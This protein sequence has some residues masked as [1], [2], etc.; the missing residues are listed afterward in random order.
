MT[1]PKHLH[2]VGIKGVGMTPLAVIAKQAGIIVTGSDVADTFITDETLARAGITPFIGFSQSHVGRDVDLV[3]ATGAHGGQENVEVQ[4]AKSR[5]IPV[6]MKGE[7]VGEYMQGGILGRSFSGISVAG[8]H[9]KTTTTAMIA[10]IFATAGM[11]PS[12]LTGTSSI[13][14]LGASGALGDGNYFI[15]EA[16]EYATDPKHDRTPQFLWQH[17]EIAVFT[18]IELDH[19][20]IYA[21]VAAV[22]EAFREFADNLPSTGLL[23]GCGDDAHVSEIMARR[24]G[25]SITYG[26]GTGNDYT[27]SAVTQTADGVSF[28]LGSK[29]EG[30]KQFCL[31]VFGEHNC[32]NATAA[33]IVAREAGLETEQ[34]ARGLKLFKGAKRRMERVG[35]LPSGALLYDDYAHH[36]TEIE[37]TLSALRTHF[38]DK[39]I[40]CIFQPHTASRT[41]KLFNE[42]CEALSGAD[43]IILAPIYASKRE[44][45]DTSISSNMLADCLTARGNKAQALPAFEAIREHLA[46]ESY[47]LDTIIITVGAGDIYK[48]QDK[49]CYAQHHAK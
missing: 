41:K 21:D 11:S 4:E 33:I 19:P 7:A 6:L 43:E 2:F 15:A 47:G 34:I 38:P 31:S 32:F 16:D 23:V 14:P 44:E 18:N 24:K 36:P 9:G 10:T 35:T 5:G 28:R 29:P 20:D 46:Q 40:V 49:L 13:T 45:E 12:F 30:H 1:K 3:I 42:F 37:K 27:V 39:K 25:R 26:M 8:S 48:L 17:P 22:E